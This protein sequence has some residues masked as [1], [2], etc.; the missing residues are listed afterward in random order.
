M[1]RRKCNKTDECDGR[2]PGMR[3]GQICP[4]YGEHALI[5]SGTKYPIVSCLKASHC[6]LG[7]KDAVCKPVGE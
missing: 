5:G 2:Y 7:K 6:L 1:N 3:K 4:H